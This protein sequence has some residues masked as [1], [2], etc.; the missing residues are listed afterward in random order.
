MLWLFFPLA[1]RHCHDY[2]FDLCSTPFGKRG[3]FSPQWDPDA[4]ARTVRAGMHLSDSVS[5]GWTNVCAGDDP[6]VK[7]ESEENATETCDNTYGDRGRCD[8]SRSPRCGTADRTFHGWSGGGTDRCG[9]PGIPGAIYGFPVFCSGLFLP[10]W[11]ALETENRKLDLR[12]YDCSSRHGDGWLADFIR[13]WR[14]GELLL[15]QTV[16]C[17]VAS[18]LAYDRTGCLSDG[19]GEAVSGNGI[20]CRISCGCGYDFTYRSQRPA[21]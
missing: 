18:C 7:R 16:L 14:H 10:A 11:A 5:G 13:E 17:A 8:S 12:P 20:L 3:D 4:G 21:L 6:L 2:V 9:R 1:G 19:G 15:L